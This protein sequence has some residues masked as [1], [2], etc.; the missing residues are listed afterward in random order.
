MTLYLVAPNV[1]AFIKA[2]P[3]KEFFEGCVT[4]LGGPMATRTEHAQGNA[5]PT[6]HTA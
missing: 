6:H 4:I 5:N 1:T 2:H 3:R